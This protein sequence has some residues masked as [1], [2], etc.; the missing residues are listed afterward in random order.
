MA[1]M[2]SDIEVLKSDVASLHSAIDTVCAKMDILLSMQVQLVQLQERHEH[3]KETLNSSFNAI[4]NLETLS[5][6]NNMTLVK[7]ISLVRGFV[8]AIV[9]LF[10]FLQWYALTEIENVENNIKAVQAVDR[11]VIL[12][13]NKV[14]NLYDTR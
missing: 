3:T 7:S 4:R 10:G 9:I 2:V 12:L 14:E 5:Q 6:T 13:E 11:R 8:I 1:D